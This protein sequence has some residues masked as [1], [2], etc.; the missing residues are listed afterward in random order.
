MGPSFPENTLSTMGIRIP[1]VPQEVP[2]AKE[3][4]TAM[5]NTMAGRKDSRV[6]AVL[7]TNC[8]MKI[9]APRLSVIAFRVQAQVRIIMAGTMAQKP[10]GKDA[11]HSLKCSTRRRRKNTTVKRMVAKDP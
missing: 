7:S 4:P 11:M 9:R 6:P 1:K 8:E 5:R 2:V 10:S 3:R